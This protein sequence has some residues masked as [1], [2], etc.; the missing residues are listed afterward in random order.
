MKSDRNSAL[1]IVALGLAVG[2]AA[3]GEPIGR[4]TQ[5]DSPTVTTTSAT[6]GRS[7]ALLPA[8]T[9]ADLPIRVARAYVMRTSFPSTVIAD[10]ILTNRRHRELVIECLTKA[11]FEKYGYDTSDAPVLPSMVDSFRLPLQWV[12]PPQGL[13]PLPDVAPGIGFADPDAQG[14]VPPEMPEDELAAFEAAIGLCES[15]APFAGSIDWRGAEE[16]DQEMKD[17]AQKAMTSDGFTAIQ[18]SYAKCLQTDG[19]DLAGGNGSDEFTIVGLS[20]QTGIV[21][22][23]V[24]DLDTKCRTPLYDDFIVLEQDRWE[25]W[26]R[27]RGDDLE[28]L[29][30]DW[31]AIEKESGIA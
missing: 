1:T 31:A 15:R 28:S 4:A 19:A 26:L 21:D 29:V 10:Y 6:P 27:R 12:A 2:L 30:E 11:G 7:E 3:C 9:A 13:V 25:E 20:A 14:W 17:I 16:I 24:L 18:Q 5:A 23:G 22:Q 8:Q